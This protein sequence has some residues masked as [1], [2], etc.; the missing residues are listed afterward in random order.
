MLCEETIRIFRIKL[1]KST[2]YSHY[3]LDILSKKILDCL[4]KMKKIEKS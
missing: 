4:N 1:C 2:H 3:K